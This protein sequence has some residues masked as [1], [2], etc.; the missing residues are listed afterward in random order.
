MELSIKQAQSCQLRISLFMLF[1]LT[2]MPLPAFSGS[3]LSELMTLT[4]NDSSLFED[5]QQLE[6]FKN[7]IISDGNE[8]EFLKW[9]RQ[10][11]EASDN[12]EH[13]ANLYWI[14]GD[15]SQAAKFA[16]KQIFFLDSYKLNRW[17]ARFR[18]TG[19]LNYRIFLE[20]ILA[21]DSSDSHIK[22]M[23]IETYEQCDARA[24]ALMEA[25]LHPQVKHPFYWGKNGYKRPEIE[26]FYDLAY[27]LMRCYERHGD[28]A[29][30]ISLGLRVASGSRPFNWQISKSVNR[31]DTYLNAAMGLLIEHADQTVLDSLKTLWANCEDFPA[32]RQLN[33][34]Y[35][36]TVARKPPEKGYKWLNS[37][38]KDISVHV[39]LQNVLSLAVDSTY[40]YAGHPWGF[41]V[42]SLDGNLSGIVTLET[43]GLYLATIGGYV[44]VGTPI[45]LYRVTPGTWTISYLPLNRDLSERERR[46]NSRDFQNGVTC[47]EVDGNDLWI[48]TRRNIQVLSLPAQIVHVFTQGDLKFDSHASWREFIF[49]KD[50]VWANGNGQGRR[51]ERAKGTWE[52]VNHKSRPIQII[53]ADSSFILGNMYVDHDKRNRPC[54]I[55]RKKLDVTLIPLPGDTGTRAKLY[56]NQFRY[57]GTVGESVIIGTNS[58]EFTLNSRTKTIAEFDERGKQTLAT[59]L[60]KLPSTLDCSSLQRFRYI[61]K[62]KSWEDGGKP[63]LFSTYS[64]IKLSANS[65]LIGIPS[66]NNPEYSYPDREWFYPHHS[67][68]SNVESGGLFI[69]DEK[70]CPRHIS[71]GYATLTGNMV[72][73]LVKEQN[74]ARVW[75]FTD[76]GLTILDSNAN[77]TGLL[78]SADG[79]MANVV[80]SGCIVNNKLYTVLQSTPG[81]IGIID[82]R[83]S[84]VT[85]M[86]PSD[87]LA[88]DRIASVEEYGQKVKITYDYVPKRMSDQYTLY[89]PAYLDPITNN[90]TSDTNQKTVLNRKDLPSPRRPDTVQTVPLIG[91]IVSEKLIVGNKE[92][93]CGTHGMV[94]INKNE[95]PTLLIDTIDRPFSL[96]QDQQQKA[97]ALKRAVNVGTL[98]QLRKALDDLNPYYRIKVL[99]ESKL[100]IP[101]ADTAEWIDLVASQLDHPNLRLRCT[102]LL[103]ARN[104][105]NDTTVI[106]YLK[107]CLNDPDPYIRAIAT[108]DLIEQK[109]IPPIHHIKAILEQPQGFG[110]FP[111]GINSQTGIQAE[112]KRL[113]RA[114]SPIAT[115]DHMKLLID[116]SPYVYSY[117]FNESVFPLLGKRVAQDNALVDILLE[118]PCSYCSDS[119][120]EGFSPNVFR[121]AGKDILPKLHQAIRHSDNKVRCNAILGCGF[122]KDTSS[123]FYL[124]PVL[125]K[126]TGEIRLVALKALVSLKAVAAIP[127]LINLFRFSSQEDS[128]SAGRQGIPQ[129]SIKIGDKYYKG[130]IYSNYGFLNNSDPIISDTPENELVN[131]G[132]LEALRSI[133]P[134]Y[135]QEF[136]RKL[137]RDGEREEKYESVKMLAY[138]KEKDIEINKKLLHGLLQNEDLSIRIFSATSLLILNEKSVYQLIKSMVGTSHT[139]YNSLLLEDLLRV[140]Q[141]KKLAF[142]R[143]EITSILNDPHEKESYRQLASKLLERINSR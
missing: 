54:I 2:S 139:Y 56:T 137:I 25:L 7:R 112:K 69:V 14:S 90:I 114:L 117:D 89:T 34:K 32:L 141:A 91:G 24:T 49:E 58:P 138:A 99:T 101:A 84:L 33:R 20:E 60:D 129:D 39:S 107:S 23:L 22:L 72:Y 115:V 76:N 130:T 67:F 75:L 13:C 94:V 38:S 98:P 123:I 66:S 17:V 37:L 29:A 104:F 134:S 16:A 121:F 102:A 9:A 87:G 100:Q 133:D 70:E 78:T 106:R 122:I 6:F 63:I 77:I 124:V 74:G 92:Y 103:L 126:D 41:S 116:Y 4:V 5:M 12:L 28:S 95:V 81:G 96:S 132:I 119:L 11:A 80:K 51:F 105:R 45:G 127:V 110:N 97:E 109:I 125:E 85:S 86:F 128:I 48:G 140:K 82:T 18:E 42:Y 30:M 15:Y 71:S 10:T 68:G 44:W 46:L 113:Y 35:H 1:C 136:Y 3:A 31:S 108:I 40:M 52:A 50:Y 61:S 19:T 57:Y 53:A 21:Q 62:S 55:D 47:L 26:N 135:C 88:H 143:P 120:C 27:R 79:L 36:K 59:H 65:F 118:A 73:S 111:Y 142:I 8:S 83:T 64:V 93:I 43:P 131:D